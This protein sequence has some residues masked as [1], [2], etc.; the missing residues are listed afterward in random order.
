MLQNKLSSNDAQ[1][2]IIKLTNAGN[3]VATLSPRDFLFSGSYA[4]RFRDPAQIAQQSLQGYRV[5]YYS[6]NGKITYFDTPK[7]VVPSNQPPPSYAEQTVC[8]ADSDFICTSDEDCP[9]GCSKCDLGK[10]L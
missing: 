5:P 8:P 1:E 6:V 4:Y 3:Q 10:C 9:A 2:M 7:P